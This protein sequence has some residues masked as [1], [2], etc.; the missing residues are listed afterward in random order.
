MLRNQPVSTH[1]SLQLLRHV[2][3]C[4]VCLFRDGPPSGP[5]YL[6]TGFRPVRLMS[7]PQ[8]PQ[9]PITCPRT[10]LGTIRCFRASCRTL[11][12]FR[13]PSGHTNCPRAPFGP[14]K[15]PWAPLGQ[16]NCPRSTRG[17]SVSPRVSCGQIKCLRAR[18]CSL[19]QVIALVS[20]R[21]TR[22]DPQYRC[23]S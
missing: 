5:W 4:P 12:W 1:H 10:P 14:I 15:R 13:E 8:G 6:H 17:H 11:H 9:D 3:W 21:A 20:I 16:S 7:R 2:M 23:S 18:P 19:T 22:H